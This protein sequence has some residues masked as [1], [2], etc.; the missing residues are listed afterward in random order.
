MHNQPAPTQIQTIGILHLI[1]G[2]MN[3]IAGA[4]WTLA[5]FLNGL[6]TF[7]IGCVFCLPA[8]ITI[9]VGIFELLS[10]IKH[11]SSDHRGLKEPKTVAIAEIVSGLGCSM[12]SMIMGIVTLTM[13]N[14][15]R[16]KSTITGAR[17]KA[18]CC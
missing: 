13:L 16:S 18:S 5:G 8:F 12:I 14:D 4:S 17:W 7:G 6:L 15:P 11:L 1:G 2:I 10:G 3:L 9:P